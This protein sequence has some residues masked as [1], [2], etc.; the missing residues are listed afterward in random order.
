ML[1]TAAVVV[2]LAFLLS[3]CVQPWASKSTGDAYRLRVIHLGTGVVHLLSSTVLAWLSVGEEPWQAPV[4]F[5]ESS[6][7]YSNTTANQTSCSG[8]LKCFS[9]F[10]LVEGPVKIEVA[11]LSVLFGLISGI[12]HMVSAYYPEYS[13]YRSPFIRRRFPL[14]RPQASRQQSAASTRSDG[15]TTA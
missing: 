4:N 10:R 12:G 3:V 9:E 11:V 2:S 8:D 5:I 6:W 1:L 13:A 7:K 14:T 15:P